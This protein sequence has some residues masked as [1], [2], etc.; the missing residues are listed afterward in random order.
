MT[1]VAEINLP[2]FISE[3]TGRAFNF[4]PGEKHDFEKAGEKLQMLRVEYWRNPRAKVSE[5]Q[6]MECAH[7]VEQGKRLDI[8]TGEL[9]AFGR[10]KDGFYYLVLRSQ[11]RRSYSE[12]G[13]YRWAYRSLSTDK[14]TFLS[15]SRL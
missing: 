9:I 10:N 2:N 8:Y 5:R 11:Q 14:G 15:L 6:K 4:E 3:V 1:K 12:D 7:R 13:S